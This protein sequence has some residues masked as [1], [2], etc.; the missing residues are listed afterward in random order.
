M[1]SQKPTYTL[2]IDKQILE[3]VRIFAEEDGRSLNKEIEYI[4]KQ[5]TIDR[6]SFGEDTLNIKKKK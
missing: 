5:Y 3:N 6:G 2:R 1:P 4:L